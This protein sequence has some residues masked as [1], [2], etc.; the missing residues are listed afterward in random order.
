[1]NSKALNVRTWGH[2]TSAHRQGEGSSSP[3]RDTVIA[4]AVILAHVIGLCL[5]VCGRTETMRLEAD[6]PAAS[7]IQVSLVAAPALESK[8]QTQPAPQPK[9]RTPEKP[10]VKPVPPK[11]HKAEVLSS[12][13]PSERTVAASQPAPIKPITPPVTPTRSVET[14]QTPT[15]PQ[16]VSTSQPVTAP[17]SS[18][19]AT[20]K[21]LSAGEL[22]QLGCQIP[23]PEYPPKAKRLEQSG[24]V[25]IAMTI[26][27]D[28][29]LHSVHVARSSGYASLDEAA[30]EAVSSGHCHPYTDGGVVRT[31]TASQAVTF[32]LN[33]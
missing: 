29:S 19:P 2:P 32:G 17:A 11:P 5:V 31:V 33:D 20:S 27:S 14:A 9:P 21:E 25:V 8:S 18:L 3:V 26:Q 12:A 7:S 22:K 30:V 16:A 15:S 13:A 28:G 23:R 24:T 6:R 4:A 1:M 10:I